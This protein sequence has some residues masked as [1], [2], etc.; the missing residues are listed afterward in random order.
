[1]TQLPE[2]WRDAGAKQIPFRY[3]SPIIAYYLMVPA[4][5]FC[6]VNDRKVFEWGR[7]FSNDVNNALIS[8]TLIAVIVHALRRRKT[9][10]FGKAWWALDVIASTGVFVDGVKWLINLPRPNGGALGFPSGHTSFA[11]SLSFIILGLYPRL[12]PFWFA[13]A[14]AI[15][16]SRVEV[17]AHYPYQVVVGGITGCAIGWAV[18]HLK[19]GLLFPRLVRVF[20]KPKEIA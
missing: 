5:L 19:D 6:N 11:F 10:G 18:T 13:M 3:L 17:R 20:S 1:M 9:E 16:W 4:A 14:G 15:G 12:A 7:F 2:R 8:I